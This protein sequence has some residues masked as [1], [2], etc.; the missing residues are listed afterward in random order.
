M[1]AAQ[2][3]LPSHTRKE[4]FD[5]EAYKLFEK[6]GIDIKNTHGS[7]YDDLNAIYVNPK[8]GHKV[9]CGNINAASNLS[10]LQRNGITHVVNC[11]DPSSQ[12]FHENNKGA[13]ITYFRFPIAHW[14]NSSAVRQGKAFEFFLPFFN[15][16]DKATETGNVLIHCLAG[17]HRA[18]TSSVSY[19]LY[20]T[21]TDVSSAIR[22]A[23]A[24]RPIIDPIYSLKDLLRLLSESMP[25]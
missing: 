13:R 24:L 16:V 3:G 8:T 15:F 22:T 11:Q 10:I 12:N 25:R 21:Q 7:S 1:S 14:H 2:R 19:I 9:F 20:K 23:K 6:L 17:A 18:G 4:D 5:E